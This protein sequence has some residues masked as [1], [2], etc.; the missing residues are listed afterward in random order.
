[1]PSLAELKNIAATNS[2]IPSGTLEG[3]MKWSGKEDMR[4]KVRRILEGG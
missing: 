3:G 4:R 2:D 1:M